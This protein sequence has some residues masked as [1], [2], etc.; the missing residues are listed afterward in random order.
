MRFLLFLMMM[1]SAYGVCAGEIVAIV[2][3]EPVSSYDVEARAKLIAIQNARP[4]TDDV[5]R[6]YI[7]I[8]LQDLIDEKVKIAD[9]Q[10]QD[11]S[12]T[13][14]E[15]QE[16]MGRL[17]EQNNMPK[18]QMKKT[19]SNN[20]IPLKILQEQIK[21]DLLWI[22]V[23]QK[24]KSALIDP[25]KEEIAKRKKEIR[26]DLK[27]EGFYVAEIVLND[28]KTAEKCYKE[29]HEGKSFQEMA[30]KY[31]KGQTAQQGGEV[32]WI[33][34]NRYTPQV[35]EALRQMSA[36]E[37][38]APLKIN[39]KYVIIL[40][41]D[42]KYPITT[43]SIPVWEVAQ[44]GLPANKTA[45][46]GKQITRLHSCPD[47]MRFAEKQAAPQTAKSGMIS[48]E[49]LPRELK[50]I[51]QNSKEKQ[52]VG[53]IGAPDL[54]LFFMK[55]AVTKK[56]VVP[57]DDKIRIMLEGEQMEKL[58]QRLLKNA[59]RFAVIENKK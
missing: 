51:L 53:P 20:G 26:A 28:S 6:E 3:D 2:N 14:S 30:K 34:E 49:Q 58:S 17:E 35:M 45:L 50:E 43:D 23:I 41:L 40:L 36:G 48:P 24:N 31:S 29:L 46:L 16:A 54:D 27:E 37:L 42:R 44:M 1:I 15:I 9:A 19:L 39:K 56:E 18:G 11:F 47:F 7:S 38:S 5:K 55:C 21:A 4:I 22:Q 8:A 25:T 32:G 10:R 13:D 57:S 33:K 52:V 12:V 59:K